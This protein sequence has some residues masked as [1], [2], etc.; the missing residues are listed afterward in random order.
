MP[1]TLFDVGDALRGD[2]IA[3]NA[4]QID[5]PVVISQSHRHKAMALTARDNA[6][7]V[8]ELPL[9][10]RPKQGW[11]NSY[12]VVEI[13]VHALSVALAGGTPFCPSWQGDRR[14]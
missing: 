3:I 8:I 10:A 12:Q 14:G 4:R 5:K 11:G 6:Y 7:C 2:R 1:Q 13:S 9:R